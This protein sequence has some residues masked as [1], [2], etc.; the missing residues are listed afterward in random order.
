M[1]FRTYCILYIK[2]IK[3][4]NEEKRL[5]NTI[6]K[7]SFANLIKLSHGKQTSLKINRKNTERTITK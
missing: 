6:I 1:F 7:F 2:I 3:C 5:C 4:K